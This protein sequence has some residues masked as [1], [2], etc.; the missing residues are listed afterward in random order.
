MRAVPFRQIL[1]GDDHDRDVLPLRPCAKLIKEAN[2]GRGG[3]DL[4][5]EGTLTKQ[6]TAKADDQEAQQR[7]P[8]P[9]RQH[10]FQA[11][12]HARN[13]WRVT[14]DTEKTPYEQL[15]TNVKVWGQVENRLVPDDWVEVLDDQGTFIAVLYLQRSRAQQT[16]PVCGT[17]EEG[18]RG[19]R[20]GRD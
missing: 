4:S 20:A 12:E 19:R 13:H 3:A 14:I 15:F 6:A 7:P 2:G 9:V 5:M 18:A 11:V 17:A 8:A 16:N 1:R 10:L